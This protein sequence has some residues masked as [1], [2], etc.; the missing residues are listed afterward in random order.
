M[1][2]QPILW[3]ERRVLAAPAGVEFRPL[4]PAGAGAR[5]GFVAVAIDR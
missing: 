3:P 1:H 2:F 5:L 4:K